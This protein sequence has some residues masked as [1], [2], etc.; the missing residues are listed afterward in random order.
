MCLH[1]WK[2]I[3]ISLFI[4]VFLSSICTA[5]NSYAQ[6]STLI[7]SIDDNNLK[8]EPVITGVDE[9]VS[10]AF[11]GPNDMLVVEKLQESYTES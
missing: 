1:L 2:A 10:I 8:V 9:P 5:T 3:S 6:G 4:L 11:L 7:P